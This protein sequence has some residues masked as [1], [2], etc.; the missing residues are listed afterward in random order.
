MEKTRLVD[1]KKKIFIRSS[2][3]AISSLDE[4][5]ALNDY[6]SADEILLEIIKKA[7]REFEISNPLILEMRV[8]KGQMGTCYNLGPGWYDIKSNFTLFLDCLISEDQI[9]LVPVS[10]PMIRYPGSW[11]TAGAYEYVTDYQRP[12]IF[13]GEWWLNYP[14]E[15]FYLRGIC[16]R[17]IIPDFTKDKSFK[18]NSKKGAIYWL[19][20]EEGALG[21]YFM[22]L[23]MV[24][25]LDYV[26]QLK[27]SVQ[28]PGMSVDVLSNVDIAYQ[29][30]RARCDNFQLQSSCSSL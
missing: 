22:D 24:H 17:P 20:V 19:N 27:A 4:I 28:L 18:T 10:I 2:M 13:L 1:L 30:L 16:A 21:N 23:C 9:V 29:E 6:L 5:F 26:R 25:V 12:H 3:L 15:C 11:P 8:N 14:Y 7:L